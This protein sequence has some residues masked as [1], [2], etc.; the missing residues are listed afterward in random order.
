MG[1]DSHTV[2]TGYTSEAIKSE[3]SG[4]PVVHIG[5]LQRR[6]VHSV[7]V[8]HQ[9][10]EFARAALFICFKSPGIRHRMFLTFPLPSCPVLER[11]GTQEMGSHA[12]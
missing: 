1:A 7:G 11:Q 8:A 4:L 10:G 2:K 3:A 9:A 12:R 6:S 5:A